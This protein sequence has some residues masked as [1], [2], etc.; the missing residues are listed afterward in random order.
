MIA[1]GIV[2]SRPL[3]AGSPPP[4]RREAPGRHPPAAASV[5]VVVPR[6]AVLEP[7][8]TVWPSVRP[9]LISA[10]ELVMRPT[11]TTVVVGDAV[12]AEHPNGVVADRCR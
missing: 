6:R 9:L 7:V 4:R 1:S 10:C 12:G 3:V 8:T 2:S 11:S 5:V